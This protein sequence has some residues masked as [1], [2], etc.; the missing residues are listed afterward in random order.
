M[1]YTKRSPSRGFN[2]LLAR[3]EALRTINPTFNFGNGLDVDEID[4]LVTTMQSTLHKYNKT[5]SDADDLR[6]TIID[7]QRK[8]ND[9]AQRLLSAVLVK[10]GQDS[11]EYR[12]V[13]GTRKSEILPTG[14]RPLTF[15]PLAENGS[16]SNGST[17]PDGEGTP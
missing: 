17:N 16:E 5:L 13:G 8:A 14:S 2:K 9:V 10:Y 6:T 4:D 7:L 3:L 11:Y 1:S 12:R 15:Q